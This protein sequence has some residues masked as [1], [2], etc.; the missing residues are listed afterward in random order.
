MVCD[1]VNHQVRAK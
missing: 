1:V